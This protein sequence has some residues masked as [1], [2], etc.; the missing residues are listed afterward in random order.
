MSQNIPPQKRGW[1]LHLLFKPETEE[2][3]RV[4]Y[5]I[6]AIICSSVFHEDRPNCNDH[7]CGS[8]CNFAT[9]NDNI[10]LLNHNSKYLAQPQTK[11]STCVFIAIGV[12]GSQQ[13]SCHVVYYQI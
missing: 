1:I 13:I 2:R 9:V 11:L 5:F 12:V 6:L 8:P 7:P 10:P 3:E 4:I